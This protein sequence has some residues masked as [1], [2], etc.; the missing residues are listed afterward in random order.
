M[1]QRA[2]LSNAKP[3]SV[4][5]PLIVPLRQPCRLFLRTR[6]D[7]EE[8]L[9]ALRVPCELSRKLPQD[10]P[11]LLFQAQHSLGK[12]VG[13]WDLDPEQLE[14]MG[15]ES[16]SLDGEDEIIRGFVVPGGKALRPL[17]GVE[18]SV[19]LDGVKL[20][21]RKFQFAPLRKV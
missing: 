19:E 14:H 15:D 21:R 3:A 6:Q 7:R 17:Q 18:R 2:I 8:A 10:R 12:E 9:Q 11:Q 13:Q 16:R 1:T 20:S 4:V 5:E